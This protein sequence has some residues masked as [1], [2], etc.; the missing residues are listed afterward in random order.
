MQASL[1]LSGKC[2]APKSTLYLSNEVTD[3]LNRNFATVPI[4]AGEGMP[5]L[6]ITIMAYEQMDILSMDFAHMP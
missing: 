6:L 1:T 2:S 4:E 3:F 5:D